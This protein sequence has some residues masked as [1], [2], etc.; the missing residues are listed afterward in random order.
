MGSTNVSKSLRT[1][2]EKSSKIMVCASP[3]TVDE[4][5]GLILLLKILKTL[6]K[7]ADIV[8]DDSSLD[9]KLKELFKRFGVKYT[10]EIKPSSYVVSIDYGKAGIDRI[11]YDSDENTGKLKFFITPSSGKFD[12][13]NIEYSV[14]GNNYDLIILLN[15]KSLKDLKG[16]YDKNSELFKKRTV[17]IGHKQLG[18]VFFMLQKN[19]SL[20]SGIY[21]IFGADSIKTVNQTYSNLAVSQV[22]LKEGVWDQSTLAALLDLA[23]SGVDVQSVINQKFYRK[24]YANLDL[25]IKLMHKVRIDKKSGV[26]WALVSNDDIRFSGVKDRSVDTSGRIIF[27]ISKEFDLCF[28]AYEVEK[29]SLTVVIESNDPQKFD[30][31]AIAK[32]F[33]GRGNKYRAQFTVNDMPLKDFESRFFLVL[34]D[35]YGLNVK[36]ETTNF[37]SSDV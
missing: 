37:K 32:I 36:G 19:E 6:N 11:A 9:K 21:R 23:S 8:L 30:A 5:S 16:L 34:Q 10:N 18:D 14:Q 2:L 3:S 29:D 1:E 28:A 17:A 25:Q 35:I 27:N 13:D 26:S 20:L 12:F 22:D 31:S 7:E 33:N 24:D 4:V 15:L